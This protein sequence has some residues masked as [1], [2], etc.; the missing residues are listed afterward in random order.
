MKIVGQDEIRRSVSRSA[1]IA[2]MR[3]AVLA[4]SRGDCD[5]PMPMHLDLSS[6]GGRRGPHQVELPPAAARTSR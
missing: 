4:Q 5:T 3:E 1:A 2:A 6:G